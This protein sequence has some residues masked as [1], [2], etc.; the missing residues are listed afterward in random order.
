MTTS[1]RQQRLRS[2]LKTAGVGFGAFMLIYAGSFYTH[3]WR[4]VVPQPEQTASE[5]RPVRSKVAPAAVE[6]TLTEAPSNGEPEV[7]GTLPKGAEP[8]AHLPARA[9]MQASTPTQASAAPSSPKQTRPAPPRSRVQSKPNKPTQTAAIPTAKPP[10]TSDA[11]PAPTAAPVQ[12]Q[13]A[14]RGN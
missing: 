13:L 2:H 5:Q 3:D 8:V 10:T 7:T 11:A 12:F 4:T 9:A 14:E 1:V 6:A